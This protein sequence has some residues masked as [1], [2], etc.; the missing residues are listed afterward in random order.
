MNQNERLAMLDD[1]RFFVTVARAER[2]DGFRD[3]AAEALNVAGRL[4]RIVVESK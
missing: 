4:R 3:R 1:A 2:R